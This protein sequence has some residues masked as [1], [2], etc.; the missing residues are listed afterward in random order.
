MIMIIS[1]LPKDGRAEVQKILKKRKNM[2][3]FFRMTC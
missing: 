2:L 1:A 3:D